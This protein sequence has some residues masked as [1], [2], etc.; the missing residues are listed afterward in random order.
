MPRV[1][2]V[3]NGNENI[4][5]AM[6]G[7]RYMITQ[8][9]DLSTLPL[10]LDIAGIFNGT[11]STRILAKLFLISYVGSQANSLM[12]EYLIAGGTASDGT[13]SI[14]KT[15]RITTSQVGTYS[16]TITLT[17]PSP[18][19]SIRIGASA[20]GNASA[21]TTATLQFLDGI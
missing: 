7:N 4:W 16:P 10:K 18:F 13:Y 11:G 1:Y 2:P 21:I 15:T 9:G 19:D 6:P 20:G 3:G 5:M 17:A 12:E 14:A 8:T